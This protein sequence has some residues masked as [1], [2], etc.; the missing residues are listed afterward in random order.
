MLNRFANI[1]WHYL[2]GPLAGVRLRFWPAEKPFQI[3]AQGVAGGLFLTIALVFL[4]APLT[5]P[6]R[7]GLALIL[8]S[9]QWLYAFT[10]L[11]HPIFEFRAYGMAAGVALILAEGLK[12][13]PIAIVALI[14]VWSRLSLTR[15]RTLTDPLRFWKR[16][17]E[18]HRGS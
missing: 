16:A 10:A 15:Y 18:E 5:V 8:F 13:Y 3:L 17:E 6:I 7:L 4:F 1:F 14:I 11:P 2:S 9:P 12:S